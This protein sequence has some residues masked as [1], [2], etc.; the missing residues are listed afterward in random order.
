MAEA[1]HGASRLRRE[2]TGRSDRRVSNWQ[3]HYAS[4]AEFEHVRLRW[5]LHQAGRRVFWATST[6]AALHCTALAALSA[7]DPH[8]SAPLQRAKEWCIVVS[9]LCAAVA[10]SAAATT[11][12]E[13]PQ[14]WWLSQGPLLLGALGVLSPLAAPGLQ[15]VVIQLLPGSTAALVAPLAQAAALG[16][17]AELSAW[18]QLRM[19]ADALGVAMTAAARPHY[20]A[21]ALAAAGVLLRVLITAVLRHTAAPHPTA[22]ALSAWTSELERSQAATQAYLASRK[23]ARLA[24]VRTT[25]A[26]AGALCLAVS[27]AGGLAPWHAAYNWLATCAMLSTAAVPDWVLELMFAA[28]PSLWAGTCIALLPFHAA[29]EQ[30]ARGYV[31]APGVSCARLASGSLDGANLVPFIVHVAVGPALRLPGSV[32]YLFLVL[33]VLGFLVMELPHLHAYHAIERACLGFGLFISAVLSAHGVLCCDAAER[34]AHE[35]RMRLDAEKA[36]TKQFT[37][38]ILHEVRVPFSVVAMGLEQLDSDLE[39]GRLR[40]VDPEAQAAVQQLLNAMHVSADNMTRCVP[41]PSRCLPAPSTD[42]GCARSIMNDT[43]DLSKIEEGHLQLQYEPFD[44][45]AVLTSLSTTW[46]QP[47]A[48]AGVKLGVRIEAE[49]GVLLRS[50]EL[51][52]DAL[53]LQQIA[54]NLI[55]NAL[56]FTPRGGEVTVEAH[57][58]QGDEPLDGNG[59]GDASPLQLPQHV[60]LVLDVHD[61][62]CGIS[63]EDM[64]RLFR[65]YTQLTSGLRRA[66]G[67]GLG[68]NL[69]RTLCMCC[70]GSLTVA[71]EHGKG[72]TFTARLPYTLGCGI[73]PRAVSPVKGRPP[74]PQRSNSRETLDMLVMAQLTAPETPRAVASPAAAA[75]VAAPAEAPATPPTSPAGRLRVLVV[76]DSQLSCMV[77]VRL[78][79]AMGVAADAVYDGRAGVEAVAAASTSLLPYTF[80]FMDREMPGMDGEAAVRA[81]RA[82]GHTLPIVALT[83]GA[84][85]EDREALMAAGCTDFLIK[86]ATRAQLAQL[87]GLPASAAVAGK[88]ATSPRS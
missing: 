1:A 30:C 67:T 69:S 21:P 80:V 74:R 87:L 71:S 59:R 6:V 10:T 11:V 36:A 79:G 20:A 62:G 70:G 48:L 51:V 68:L 39:G 47:A 37:N 82:A 66:G 54:S 55:S 7:A 3:T 73:T 60:W 13:W 23:H 42:C 72:S 64:G 5:Q 46:A 22:S 19:A 29:T 17:L 16:A 58:V 49:A 50:R 78:L 9:S 35:Q 34:D 57:V 31:T 18:P 15:S 65:P 12:S 40:A 77:L 83:G 25:M 56:K 33:P 28:W 53:R 52:G 61:T 24:Q 85:P 86:P 8:G 2:S 4:L 38:Y 75:T 45:A 43:L 81:L 26:L 14:D 32:C 27:L 63:T 41:M 88:A 76:D 84:A 44:G